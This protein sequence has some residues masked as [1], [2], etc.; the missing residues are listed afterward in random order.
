MVVNP[1]LDGNYAKNV[2][3]LYPERLFIIKTKRNDTET[4]IN[5]DLQS[6]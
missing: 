1:S 3:Y 6:P 4:T 2:V 5:Q